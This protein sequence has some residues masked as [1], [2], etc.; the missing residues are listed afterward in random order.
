MNEQNTKSI[1]TGLS[2]NFVQDDYFLIRIREFEIQY[3]N[4]FQDWGDFYAQYSKGTLDKNNFDYDEWAYLC[5]HFMSALI[6]GEDPPGPKVESAQKPESD[7]GF[8]FVGRL[9]CL[10]PNN[11]SQRLAKLWPL[12]KLMPNLKVRAFRSL[13]G[14][15]IGN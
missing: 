3:H 5:R 6:E 12:A 1:N 15:M 11:I 4:D 9:Y 13:V 2:V 8:C 10:T 14:G 7:S